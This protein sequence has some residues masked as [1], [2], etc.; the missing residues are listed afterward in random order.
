MSR[1][2]TSPEEGQE[3]LGS[4]SR[5]V[6]DLAEQVAGRISQDEVED[7]LCRVLRR[8]AHLSGCTIA[9]GESRI[10]ALADDAESSAREA[11]L[12]A[13]PL[14]ISYHPVQVQI[15]RAEK[16]VEEAR[17]E[18][19]ALRAE[20]AEMAAASRAAHA[21][22]LAA[23][24][25]AMQAVAASRQ[26]INDAQSFMD[27]AVEQ[28]A[29]VI[30]AAKSQAVSKT[31]ETYAASRPQ[32]LQSRPVIPDTPGKHRKTGEQT[33]KPDYDLASDPSWPPNTTAPWPQWD[34]PPTTLPP[35][36]PSAPV[37]RVTV[38]YPSMPS[39]KADIT[40]IP[41]PSEGEN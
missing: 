18:A 7:R 9:D 38:T 17:Q 34:A 39:P 29:A 6:L 22:A 20:A 16:L 28:A 26:L 36:H 8:S 13:N 33:W 12:G 35:D 14:K 21:A 24:D 19:M 25:E 27:R 31:Q 4:L 30:A 23:R 15:L 32:D 1:P 5:D 2:P 41:T 3:A 10:R 37:P 11:L 40:Q